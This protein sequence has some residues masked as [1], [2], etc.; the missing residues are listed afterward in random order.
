MPKATYRPSALRGS[1][2]LLLEVRDD[3]VPQLEHELRERRRP[4][5][6][7]TR[8]HSASLRHGAGV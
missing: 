5:R 6:G 4:R 3:E 1:E 2:R 7:P 8:L